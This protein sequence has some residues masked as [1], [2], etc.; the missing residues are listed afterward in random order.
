MVLEKTLESPL[1]C[2]ESQPVHPKGDQSWILIGRTDAE[3]EI[4]ILW[5]LDVKNWLIGKDPDAGKDGRQEEKG[6]E[7]EM[8]G[9]H[10]R[11]NGHEFE[12]TPGAGDGR[13]AWRA[14]VHGVAES[15]TR[16]SDW[17][18]LNALS[19]AVS[20]TGENVSSLIITI[21]QTEAFW[22]HFWWVLLNISSTKDTSLLQWYLEFL[23]QQVTTVNQVPLIPSRIRTC[24]FVWTA[25]KATHP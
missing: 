1:D 23:P 21:P 12:W 5:P 18:E 13:E 19:K 17:T 2:E 22:N 10:H 16:R 9:W 15:R 25:V 20:E 4:S 11:L 6:T 24:W 14:V 3:A 8:V 7:D